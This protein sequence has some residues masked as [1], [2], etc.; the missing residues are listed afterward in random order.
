MADITGR[1]YEAFTEFILRRLGYADEWTEGQSYQYL[2]EK[3]LEALCHSSPK[4]CSHAHACHVLS[5]ERQMPYGP[6]YDPDFFLLREGQP[7]ACIHVTHW[8]NPRD[9]HRK[10]WRTIEDHFQYKTLFSHSFLSLNLVFVALDEGTPPHLVIDSEELVQIHG[11]SPANGAMHATSYDTTIL[12][13]ANFSPLEAF[14]AALPTKIPGNPR[15]RRA[16]YNS[17]WE[18]VYSSNREARCTIDRLV[19]FFRRALE[20][21]PHSRYTPHAVQH[22]QDICFQGRQKAADVR[23]TCSRYRKGMQHAFILREIIAR[24]WP[25]QLDPDDALWGILKAPPRFLWNRLQSMLRLP[26]DVPE[27][28]LTSFRLLLGLS[29]SVWKSVGH[30]LYS[31]RMPA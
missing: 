2:Y 31:I 16:L 23:E 1:I 26:E 10:F 24:T 17:V 29:P 11:W 4:I 21:S 14:E 12:F 5:Q 7:F 22:L 30:N 19:R 27:S 3:H 15:K 6:W 18:Q 13:P 8:S 28:T 20:G 9:S 25:T